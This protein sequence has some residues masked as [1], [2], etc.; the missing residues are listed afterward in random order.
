MAPKAVLVT[1][2]Y[3]SIASISIRGIIWMDERQG[4]PALQVEK[5]WLRISNP[6]RVHRVN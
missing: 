1:G 6:F 4:V 3:V 5:V 2:F